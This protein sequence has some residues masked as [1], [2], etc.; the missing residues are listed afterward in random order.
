MSR[1]T[2]N[3]RFL[4]SGHTYLSFKDGFHPSLESTAGRRRQLRRQAEQVFALTEIEAIAVADEAV[5]RT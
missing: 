2:S 4:H 3:C 5:E 1:T